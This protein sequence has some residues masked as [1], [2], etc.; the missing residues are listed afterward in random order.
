[1][2][3]RCRPANISDSRELKQ[4]GRRIRAALNFIALIPSRS[5]LIHQTSANV[6]ELNSKGLYQSSRKEKEVVVLCSRP[7]QNVKLGTFTLYSCND[8]KK[9]YRNARCT[10]KFSILLI[11]CYCFFPAL[12]AV[13]VV[14]A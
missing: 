13:A 9:M 12:V 11:W 10:C 8:G 6:F 2:T 14:V 4:Q 7:R 3:S 5:H 1:M